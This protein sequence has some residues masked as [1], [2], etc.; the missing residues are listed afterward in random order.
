MLIFW[1][2]GP[3]T[4]R[5]VTQWRYCKQSKDWRGQT[6]FQPLLLRSEISLYWRTS[7]AG[8]FFFLFS[9]SSI[10]SLFP[11]PFLL[12]FSDTICHPSMPAA[13][14]NCLPQYA[15]CPR[16]LPAPVCLLPWAIAC[17]S[18]AAALGNCPLRCAVHR[19]FVGVVVVH[20]ADRYRSES[21]LEV[22]KT[23][24]KTD[25]ARATFWYFLRVLR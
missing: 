3:Y 13:L 14:G 22:Q 8:D 23:T 25:F 15:C 20:D 7:C 10:F 21:I 6:Y 18:M 5:I 4:G 24:K 1:V 17:P 12:F 16:Q 2:T 9:L 11:S 19:P